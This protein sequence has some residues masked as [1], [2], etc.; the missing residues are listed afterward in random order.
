[1][2]FKLKSREIGA[3]PHFERP[4]IEFLKAVREDG[5]KKLISDFYD[6]VS[7]SKIA[8]FFPQ[9]ENEL[10]VVKANSVDFFMQVCS[11][12]SY[13]DSNRGGSRMMKM[14]H[15]NFSITEKDRIEWMSCFEEALEGVNIDKSLKESMWDY[16]EKFSS[17]LVN[18]ETTK[19]S[20]YE[21]MVKH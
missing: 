7:E 21:D 17:H 11:D 1:M 10:E 4:N 16:L 2:H 3:M 8:H 9:D 12:N 6:I 15:D 13:F 5:L 19:V 20:G 18:V 14:M